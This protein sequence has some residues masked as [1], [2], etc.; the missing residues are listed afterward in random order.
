M[1]SIRSLLVLMFPPI[2][3]A[4]RSSV[5]ATPAA[6]RPRLGPGAADHLEA[7]LARARERFTE[8]RYLTGLLRAY[9]EA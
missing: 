1:S 6:G 4:K 9:G 8:V 7:A 5:T 3:H 2:S